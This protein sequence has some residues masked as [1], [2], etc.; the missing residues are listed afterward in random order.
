MIGIISTAEAEMAATSICLTKHAT[1]AHAP[2]PAPQCFRAPRPRRTLLFS[3]LALAAAVARTATTWDSAPVSLLDGLQASAL[4]ELKCLIK[5]KSMFELEPY[6]SYLADTARSQFAA[7]VGA[8][9]AH[10]YMES[11][12]Y[13]W[14]ANAQCLSRSLDPH[15]DFIY[16]GGTAT[17]HGV[18]LA[19]A[20]GSFATEANATKI[21]TSASKKYL[22]QVKPFVA[23]SSPFGNIIHGYSIAFGSK[24]LTTQSFLAVSETRISKPR[25]NPA[26]VGAVQASKAPEE[27][28][29]SMALATHRSNFLLIGAP[30]VTNWIDRI[31]SPDS[32]HPN[33]TDIK[34][35]RLKYEGKIYLTRN[36]RLLRDETH[37]SWVRFFLLHDLLTNF[38][39]FA[40]FAIEEQAGI[41]FLNALSVSIRDRRGR[42]PATNELPTVQPI[43]FALSDEGGTA[44]PGT[45]EKYPY[46]L[47][48]DG[49]ALLSNPFRSEP[50]GIVVWSPEKGILGN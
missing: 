40:T 13:A 41:K 19:E 33:S 30:D 42:V 34:F 11:L 2:S 46:A 15:A 27:M 24:P 44:A 36:P 25:K 4:I 39:P 12:G 3:P 10:L 6:F 14:R 35:F 17:G 37:S 28:P 21:A 45:S 43:G 20:H 18:V 38:A 47:F 8:G 49:L 32:D 50:P 1:H 26:S 29:A 23:K 31:R 9:I 7:K 5:N 22:K 48:R 16:G